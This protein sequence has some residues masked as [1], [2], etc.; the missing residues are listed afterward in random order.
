MQKYIAQEVPKERF[1]DLQFEQMLFNFTKVGD[2]DRFEK[3]LS[4]YSGRY[5]YNLH[6]VFVV[7]GRDRIASREQLQM[8]DEAL[9]AT[10]VKHQYDLVANAWLLDRLH[11]AKRGNILESPFEIALSILNSRVAKSFLG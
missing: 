1:V 8:L 11:V 6:F 7:A 2:V 10:G 3:P 4:S 9:Q 5:W